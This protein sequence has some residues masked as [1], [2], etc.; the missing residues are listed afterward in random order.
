MT[1]TTTVDNIW[2][3]SGSVVDPGTAKVNS[4]WAAEIPALETQ[5][6]WQNRVDKLLQDIEI[7]GI[8]QYSS[9]TVYGIGSWV[10]ASDNEIYK[11]ITSSNSGND[12]VSSPVNWTPFSTIVAVQNATESVKGIVELSSLAE[13]QVGTDATRAVSPKNLKDALPQLIPDASTATKGKVQLASNAETQ[14]GADAVRAVTPAGL[15]SVTATE[16]RAGLVERAT[17]AE[18]LAGSDTIRYISPKQFV[19]NVNTLVPTAT[20]TIKGKIEIATQTET[21]TGTDTIRAVTPKTLKDSI[22]TIVPDASET[23]KGKVE[24]ATQ[25]E[26]DTGTDDTR[27]VTPKKLRLGVSFS[28]GTDG[29]LALPSWLG[30]VIFN[31]GVRAYGAAGTYTVT[32]NKPYTT[33]IF[34][35]M[36]QPKTAIPFT[37]DIA[38]NS[39]GINGTSLT[40][41]RVT[42]DVSVDTSWFSMGY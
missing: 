5:N 20:E 22:Q 4:G 18:A 36:G 10:T 11:S 7:H 24:I 2:A 9:V 21:N 26:T 1:R 14:T 8:M 15:F 41:I 16:T 40:T 12:P 23:V 34:F 25:T 19:D 13:T 37:T 30:G 17:D 32:L 42:T 39:A 35:A 28:L 3:S 33:R 29:Y 31:W 38:S 6:F 27:A